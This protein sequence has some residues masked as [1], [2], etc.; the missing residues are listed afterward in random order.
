MRAQ[1]GV[2]VEL[3]SFFNFSTKLGWVVTA[4]PR[5]L[6]HQERDLVPIV[7]EVGWASGLVWIG[8]ENL[9]PTRV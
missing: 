3:Y 4:T 2:D 1:R 9:D 6:Y 8:A 7:Q 5:Q